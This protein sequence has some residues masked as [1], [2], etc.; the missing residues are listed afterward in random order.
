[1]TL[2]AGAEVVMPWVRCFRLVLLEGGPGVD[3]LDSGK[4]MCRCVWG[5]G[6]LGFSGLGANPA[7]AQIS[8]R[9]WI[10]DLLF[11]FPFR[12]E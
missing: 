12:H 6:C 5:E 9:G 1:M 8:R 2:N 10:N 4:I 3:P 7:T 11:S